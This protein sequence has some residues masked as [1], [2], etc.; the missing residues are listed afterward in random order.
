MDGVPVGMRC[1]NI[2]MLNNEAG[3]WPAGNVTHS[4]HVRTNTEMCR[5]VGCHVLLHEYAV[6]RLLIEGHTHVRTASLVDRRRTALVR[7]Q[8]RTH[9]LCFTFTRARL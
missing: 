6:G 3:S 1:A 5:I 9:V 2:C 7:R 8:R 4:L